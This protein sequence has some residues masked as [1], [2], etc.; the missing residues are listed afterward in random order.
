VRAEFFTTDKGVNIEAVN[1]EDINI[2]VLGGSLGAK[3]VN[4]L[5][6]N[7][8]SF[9]TQ[10]SV[11]VHITGR[12][13]YDECALHADERYK[14]FAYIEKEMP[15]MLQAASFVIGRAG[16]GTVWES[17]ACGKAM[18]LIPLAGSGTRGD[19]IENAH[20]FEKHGAAITLIHPTDDSFKR[21]IATLLDD[22]K[23]LAA[24]SEASASIGRINAAEKIAELIKPFMR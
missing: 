7:N 17:A 18:V 21:T 4:T 3:E 8:L 1:I 20:Y 16:A 23:L 11:I 6:L 14:P 13:H 2:L 24:M 19:Q 9:L 12:E 5:I 10:R 15:A 22:K